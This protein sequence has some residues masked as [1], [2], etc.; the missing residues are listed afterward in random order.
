MYKSD[1]PGWLAG[2]LHCTLPPVGGLVG[3]KP[4]FF[5]YYFIF[6]FFTQPN[7]GSFPRSLHLNSSSLCAFLGHADMWNGDSLAIGGGAQQM[8]VHHGP[9]DSRGL[10][11]GGAAAAA[12]RAQPSMTPS[13]HHD[14]HF[15]PHLSGLAPDGFSL[16]SVA[17]L[18]TP[19]GPSHL[20]CGD[21][22]GVPRVP[23][24]I[25]AVGTYIF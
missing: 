9:S 25:C 5:L 13:D 12:G 4:A 15:L 8:P 19:A 24:E 11:A 6:I 7:N 16:A 22:W 20:A 21:R 18:Q 23:C 2:I 10:S 3:V 1:K 14:H 17:P